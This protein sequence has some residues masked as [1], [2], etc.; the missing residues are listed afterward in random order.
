MG[1]PLRLSCTIYWSL[2]T[3]FWL[4]AVSS[5]AAPLATHYGGGFASSVSTKRSVTDFT[6]CEVEALANKSRGGACT[7]CPRDITVVS[8]DITKGWFD[9]QEAAKLQKESEIDV[10]FFS[11]LNTLDPLTKL[12]DR[13]R[14]PW[15]VAGGLA[16]KIHGQSD[17]HTTDI[18]MVVQTTMPRL[19]AA[20]SKDKKYIVP[21]PGWP[22]ESHLRVYRNQGSTE[23]PRY[24]EIDLVIAGT[25][26]TP[27]SVQVNSKDF[28]VENERKKLLNI[29]VMRLGR[30]FTSKVHALAAEHRKKDDKDMKDISWII[31]KTPR[32]LLKVQTDLS[33][34]LRQLVIKH[35]IR[36]KSPLVKKARQLLGVNSPARL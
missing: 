19:R 28:T 34:A 4:L 9:R 20:L 3:L 14:I 7:Q 8:R 22:S 32:A 30:I 35:L 25:L 26:T 31:D 16:L 33:Y 23:R 6:I 24:I 21:G 13:N 11:I 10:T 18:D 15:A 17:R 36:L 5:W 29:H 1:P 12:L 2:I 27:E